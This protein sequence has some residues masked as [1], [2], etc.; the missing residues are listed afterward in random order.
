MGKVSHLTLKSAL[1]KGRLADFA[2]Q[3]DKELQP[4]PGHE[5]RFKRLI[6]R[7]VPVVKARRKAGQT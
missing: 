7:A 4:E 3:Q 1:E 6:G 5:G 2:R